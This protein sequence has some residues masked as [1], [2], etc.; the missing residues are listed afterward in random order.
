VPQHIAA[1]SGGAVERRGEIE[2]EVVGQCRSDL[3]PDGDVAEDLRLAAD[4]ERRDAPDVDRPDLVDEHN[5]VEGLA[6][7]ARPDLD[8]PG[9]F[10]AREVTGQTAASE[11][12][13]PSGVRRRALPSPLT[14]A[15]SNPGL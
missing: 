4:L 13:L 8:L 11:P 5:G 12:A 10:A 2:S 15:A 7:R 14:L 6:C 1:R 9:Y 3:A